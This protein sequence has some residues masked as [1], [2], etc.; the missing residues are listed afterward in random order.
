MSISY[1][2]NAPDVVAEDFAGETL[3]LNLATG[4]YFRLRGAA[5]PIWS[6]LLAGNSPETILA[7]IR[8]KRPEL[9][10]KSF[11]FFGRLVELGLIRP[12]ANGAS[13]HEDSLVDE[14]WSAEA[15]E[16]EDFGELAELIFADPIHDVDEQAGWPTP[17]PTP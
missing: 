12:N 17:R 16:I 2:I 5:S 13:G 15:P 10:E 8:A 4:H 7:S 6:S 3:I 11:A 14:T 1:A 9:F